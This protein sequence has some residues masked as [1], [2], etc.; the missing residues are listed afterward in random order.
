MFGSSVELPYS[1]HPTAVSPSN[2]SP[3]WA[4]PSRTSRSLRSRLLRV[5]NVFSSCMVWKYVHQHPPNTTLWRSTRASNASHV[6]AVRARI[7]S[8]S[9]E[10]LRSVELVETTSPRSADAQA[11]RVPGGIEEH[12]ERRPGLVV[13]L[14]G[15]EGEDRGLGLVEV[16]DVHVEVHLLRDVLPRPLG[17]GVG[18]D[19]L[20]ADAVAVVGA[21][22]GPVVVHLDRPVQQGAVEGGQGG[23]VGAVED[24]GGVASDSHAATL[25]ILADDVRPERPQ[26]LRAR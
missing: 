5:S 18:V 1:A 23:G 20:E 13:V 12:P 10:P 3:A 25:A 19:L 26:R 24:E 15:A 4:R 2:T 16:V 9:V 11:E 8:P 14:G 7:E 6:S 17:S 22:L 21:D